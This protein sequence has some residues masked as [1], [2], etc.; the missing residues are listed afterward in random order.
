MAADVRARTVGIANRRAALRVKGV[1][2][3]RVHDSVKM[4][5]VRMIRFV[6]RAVMTGIADIRNFRQCVVRRM[7]PASVRSSGSGR[8]FTV[9]GCTVRQR[10][11]MCRSTG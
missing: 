7:R 5:R 4:I 3:R 11:R 1:Q 6:D 8:R 2:E 10:G 9:A